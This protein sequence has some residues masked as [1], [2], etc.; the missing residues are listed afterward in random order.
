MDERRDR[1]LY[2]NPCLDL[3]VQ[4]RKMTEKM[5]KAVQEDLYEDGGPLHPPDTQH[6]ANLISSL[7]E[8]GN[9]SPCLDIDIPC[10]VIP[11][12]TKGN[13]HI[14]F[15]SIE[16]TWEKYCKL[17]D[18]LREA[19]IIEEKYYDHTLSRGQSLLRLPWIKKYDTDRG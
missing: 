5:R 14:Y 19:G 15:P 17:L 16:L 2:Y 18:A 11:S 13:C 7:L 12:T 6:P 8:N 1:K 3:E 10:T 4:N 9:H